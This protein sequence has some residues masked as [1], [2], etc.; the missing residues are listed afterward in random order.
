MHP[1]SLAREPALNLSSLLPANLRSSHTFPGMPKND[2]NRRSILDIQLNRGSRILRIRARFFAR[3]LSK[4]DSEQMS[5]APDNSSWDK[6]SKYLH[7]V[8]GN[9]LESQ[10]KPA[11]REPREEIMSQTVVDKAADQISEVARKASRASTAIGDA[12]EDGVG[13]AKRAAKQGAEMFEEGVGLARRAVKQ[14]G[15]AAEEFL[16]DTQMRMQ[17]HLVLTVIATFAAGI[18]AGALFGLLVKR[19]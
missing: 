3:H 10:S 12:I 7:Q 14:S 16:N 2:S 19:D 18:T 17:R 11:Y 5:Q 9:S 4:P 6:S 13:V 1:M 8:N 15:D